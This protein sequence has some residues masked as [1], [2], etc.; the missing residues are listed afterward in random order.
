MAKCCSFRDARWA[1]CVDLNWG[2]EIKEPGWV[3][4]PDGKWFTALHRSAGHQLKNID[5]ARACTFALGY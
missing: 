5:N 3:N 4:A 2:E 1:Q